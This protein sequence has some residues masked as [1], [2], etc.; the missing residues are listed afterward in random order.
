MTTT[1]SAFYTTYRDLS[2]TGVTNLDQPPQSLPSAKF[3]AKWI[4]TLGIDEAQL[5]A[6]GVGGER[7]LRCTLVV[8]V[9]VMG[10]DTHANRWSEML[11]MVDTVNAGIKTVASRHASWEVRA[12]PNFAEVYFAVVAEIVTPEW[13]V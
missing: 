6:K 3:P 9:G 8:A 12:V 4:H 2:L 1:L 13:G 7:I 5:R 10:Q 11:A